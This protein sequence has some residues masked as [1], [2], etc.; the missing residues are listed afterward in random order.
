VDGFENAF[1]AYVGTKHCVT[2]NGA[3]TGIDMAI[4]ALD[5][6]PGDEVITQAVNFRAVPMAIGGQGGRIVFAEVDETLQL[7][8]NDVEKRITPRTR[9]IF[10]THMNGMSAPMDDLLELAKRHPHPKHGPLKGMR[11][12]RVAAATR[13]LRSASWGG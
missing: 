1:A 13:A 7:D 11:R 8:P 3:G 6:E 5:L 12:G 9:A 10:P 2:C 4:M